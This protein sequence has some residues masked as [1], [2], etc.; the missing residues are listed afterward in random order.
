VQEADE[1]GVV[2]FT[3]IY[4]GCYSGRSPHI[5]FE[6]HP[7]L[8]AATDDANR[9]A[10]S[11]IALPEEPSAIVYATVGYEQSVSNLAQVS[12]ES[13]NVFGDDGGLSQL[14]TV[15][16]DIGGGYTVELTVPVDLA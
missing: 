14:G 3:S 15:T 13:D 2:T 16:G 5:H 12:L 8:S 4:T 10:T 7:G 9:I 1:N 11:Q 6:V